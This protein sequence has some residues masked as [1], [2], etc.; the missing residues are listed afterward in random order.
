M[1]MT[2]LPIACTLPPGELGA[3]GDE[4]LSGLVKHALERQDLPE[5]YRFRFGPDG[6]TL[7]RIT[8]A[9]IAERQ[10]CRFLTFSLTAE[11]DGGPLWL[12][13]TGPDGTRAFLDEL[14]NT[15]I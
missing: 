2:N 5:G 3:R 1:T 10:C 7:Q 14:L 12:D 13:V 11:A 9:V 8:G 6:E 15:R 4:L